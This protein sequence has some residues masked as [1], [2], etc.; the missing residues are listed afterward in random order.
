MVP[1]NKF[2]ESSSTRSNDQMEYQK[3]LEDVGDLILDLKDE[4]PEIDKHPSKRDS[5]IIYRIIDNKIYIKRENTVILRL[6]FPTN[7]KELCDEIEDYCRKMI[8]H[9][10]IKMGYYATATHTKS[11]INYKK[12]LFDIYV[13]LDGDI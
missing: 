10:L 1:F 4:F 8:V 9:R 2:V 12:Y 5:D 13:S 3:M 6:W 7:R 11:P